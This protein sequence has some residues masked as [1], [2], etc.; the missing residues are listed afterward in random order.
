MALSK[1]SAM[2]LNGVFDIGKKLAKAQW[3]YLSGQDVRIYSRVHIGDFVDWKYICITRLAFVSIMYYHKEGLT[4]NVDKVRRRMEDWLYTKVSQ[5]RLSRRDN[6]VGAATLQNIYTFMQHASDT[7]FLMIDSL[8]SIV[9][10]SIKIA[11]L[12][13]NNMLGNKVS[14]SL[15]S[16][17]SSIIE[18]IMADNYIPQVG[19]SSIGVLAFSSIVRVA[20]YV[21][22]NV[23]GLFSGLLEYLTNGRRSRISDQNIRLIEDAARMNFMIRRN[24]S[25]TDAYPFSTVREMIAA[26][27]P[28]YS[29]N[30]KMRFVRDFTLGSDLQNAV[31]TARTFFDNIERQYTKPRKITNIERTK[32]N[33][34]TTRRRKKSASSRPKCQGVFKNGKPCNRFALEGSNFCKVH[35]GQAADRAEYGKKNNMLDQIHLVF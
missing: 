27:I 16:L 4:L 3:D 21:E 25:Y 15:G 26:Q 10:A 24:V 12:G 31:V 9:S 6:I 19:S 20:T 5:A 11:G 18:N 32:P 22:N 14:D 7:V 1:A 28:V 29:P 34:K 17:V 23:I 2:I 33:K 35:Q 13:V 8:I 30:R